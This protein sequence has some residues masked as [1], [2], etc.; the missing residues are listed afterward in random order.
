VHAAKASSSRRRGSFEDR[1]TRTSPGQVLRWAAAGLGLVLLALGARPSPAG[2]HL[3]ELS[4]SQI[5]VRDAL[6]LYRFKFA[7]HLLPEAGE[8]PTRERVLALAEATEDWIRDTIEVDGG[9]G[10]CRAEIDD[11]L[12]PD[13]DDDLE[14]LAVYTCDRPVETLRVR[15]TAFS[16]RVEGWR[17]IVSIRAGDRGWSHIFEQ[18]AELLVLPLAAAPRAPTDAE[19]VAP[20]ATDPAAGAPTTTPTTAPEAALEDGEPATGASFGA[21]FRLGVTHIWEGYDHLLFLAA[22]L[23]GG[24]SLATLAGMVT[25]FT[26]AHSITLVLASLGLVSLPPGPV[27]FAIAASIMF[28]AAEN[29]VHRPGRSRILVT[30]A[31]G[32]VHGFG[33]AGVLGEA[34]LEAGNLLV[35]LLAFNLGVEAGQFAIVAVAAP[36]LA[37]ALAGRR[38]DPGRKI[39]SLAIFAAGAFWAAERWSSLW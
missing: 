32:L 3:G 6:V 17:N 29:L 35:P 31:F 36:P 37:L 26:V 9:H 19:A 24:G 25:A 14:L 2:A 7:A 8:A 12:G 22:L 10:A 28:V 21:F 18:A 20:T 16:G 4:Y 23:V 34:G 27:E 13:A 33:F 1:A 38:A 15:F 30:F 11:V 5:R 39:L